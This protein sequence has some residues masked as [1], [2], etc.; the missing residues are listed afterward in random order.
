MTLLL[1]TASFPYDAIPE[2]QFLRV[3]IEHL[4][5]G[6]ERVVCVPENL[7]GRRRAVP[8]TVEVDESYAHAVRAHY[9]RKGQLYGKHLL[10]R[11][12]ASRLSYGDILR[13][14]AILRQE[15]ALARLATFTAGAE[16]TERWVCESIERGKFNAGRSM[17]YTFW[18]DKSTLGIGLAKDTFPGIRLVSRAHGYD[19]Y[20]ERYS[21]PYWPCRPA[22]LRCLDRLFPDSEAGT[23]YLARRYPRFA[24]LY[25]TARLGVGDPRFLSASSQDGA[26]RVASCSRMISLKRVG[27]L[28]QGLGRAAR[29]RPGLRIEWNHYGTGELQPAV[30]E[31]ARRESPPNLACHF[32]GYSS[33][34]DLMLF[35]RS[36]PVDVFVNVSE[37]EGTSVAIMEAI[38]CGIPVIATAVGGNPEIVSAE[39]GL[40][41]SSHPSPD[42]IAEALLDVID[43]SGEWAEKRKASR[44]MWKEKYDADKNY[45]AFVERLKAI[46]E[47]P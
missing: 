7:E 32:P 36:D 47:E 31:L 3:E 20:E 44:R 14:P 28:F 19:L 35:Y 12:L 1:F 15:P 25:E 41:L 40:L 45:G 26:L 39:N 22:A 4:A 29:Q 13:R 23:A 16:V 8:A 21:P 6:F 30:E 34:E 37:T 17:F 10:R 27:L 38:S 9:E 24:G 18:F 46:R 5:R 43:R 42:E 2:H 33:L 11:V